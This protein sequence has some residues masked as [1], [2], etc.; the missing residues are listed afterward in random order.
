MD[1]D[2]HA[3][4]GPRR[5]D[6]ILA[7]V[8]E[9]LV[10]VVRARRRERLQEAERAKPPIPTIAVAGLRRGYAPR[11]MKLFCVIGLFDGYSRFCIPNRPRVSRP[12]GLSRKMLR[13]ESMT[14]Q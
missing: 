6:R 14:R 3:A 13:S 5:E 12:I 10:G 1:R 7:E 11:N 2:A 4:G 8:L 9:R